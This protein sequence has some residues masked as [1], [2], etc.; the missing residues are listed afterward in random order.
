MSKAAR[1]MM[2]GVGSIT[3]EWTPAVLWAQAAQQQR[4]TGPE[5]V[6]Y[7]DLYTSGNTL[8]QVVNKV[9]PDGNGK[10]RILTLPEGV[11]TTS[12]N[13][14]SVPAAAS[15]WIGTSGN[16]GSGCRG[17]AGSGRNTI[18]RL[19]AN[20]TTADANK[21]YGN[22]IRAQGV[23]DVRFS[24]FQLQA[25]PQED[26]GGNK[27]YGAGIMIRS[28]DRAEFSWLYL[29]GAS[30]GFS[31][32]P[33][34]E[35]FGINV[36]DSDNVTIRD[37]EVD[38]RDLNGVRQCAS[39]FGWNGSGSYPNVTFAQNARVYRF[40]GH[41]GVAGMPT[42]W[43]TQNIYTEDLWSYSC[44]SGSGSISGHGMNHEQIRGP[45]T[46]YRPHLFIHNAQSAGTPPPAPLPN[47]A[48]TTNSGF[49]FSMLTTFED[50][51]V[52]IIEPTWD[53]CYTGSGLLI[54]AGYDGYNG[55]GTAGS[56]TNALATPPTIIKDG[57]TLQAFNHPTSGWNTANPATRYAWLH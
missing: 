27:T 12:G 40:Y 31:N 17:I 21:I 24:N 16:G 9:T 55:A 25:E 37:T 4:P 14:G 15:V 11:F 7:E 38:G 56:D 22:I 6:R 30:P 10:A 52:T 47:D 42:F 32:S 34:G 51:A 57:V 29:R 5:Y 8:Q 28:C 44:G 13:V 2:S 46:H 41:H 53:K 3:G 18:I 1:R 43:E 54:M 49:H 33:P 50:P 36:F 45:V 23:A 26:G 39:P 19:S 48:T 20:T 35:T